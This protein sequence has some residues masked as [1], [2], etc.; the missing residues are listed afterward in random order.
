MIKRTITTMLMLALLAT[1]LNASM[2][3]N[4]RAEFAGRFS[5]M[6]QIAAFCQSRN[7][8][9]ALASL[10]NLREMLFRSHINPLGTSINEDDSPS[11]LIM[12]MNAD[13]KKIYTGILNLENSLK[14]SDPLDP[15]DKQLNELLQFL[16]VSEITLILKD[17]YF[18]RI[19]EKTRTFIQ[20]AR[21]TIISLMAQTPESDTI[22]NIHAMDALENLLNLTEYIYN[23][24]VQW[25]MNASFNLQSLDIT[26]FTINNDSVFTG[27]NIRQPPAMY[28]NNTGEYNLKSP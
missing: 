9:T 22:R 6:R 19:S 7:V 20:Q 24:Q 23:E 25:L 17:D 27:F 11:G 18:F 12:R 13:V 28:V 14:L 15:N 4:D 5:R 16:V 3:G 21:N 10:N 2:S 8:N 1:T 26:T